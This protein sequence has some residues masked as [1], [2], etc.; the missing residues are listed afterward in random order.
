MY[1]ITTY[2]LACQLYAVLEASNL[3]KTFRPVSE[4]IRRNRNKASC[5][6]FDDTRA[7]SLR[8]CSHNCQSLPFRCLYIVDNTRFYPRAM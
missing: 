3:H 5:C 1:C 2:L 6:Y 8:C 7:R 4:C